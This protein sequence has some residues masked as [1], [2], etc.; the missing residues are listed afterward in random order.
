VGIGLANDWLIGAAGLALAA[1]MILRFVP[2]GD[3]SDREPGP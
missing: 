3:G 2:R 1:G